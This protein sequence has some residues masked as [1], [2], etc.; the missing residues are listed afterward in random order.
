MPPTYPPACPG[1]GPAGSCRQLSTTQV[2][3]CRGR[4]DVQRAF[5]DHGVVV[6][7]TPV[8]TGVVHSSL[9]ATIT[10]EVT[11][12]GGVHEERAR[13]GRG[14]ARHRLHA[15]RNSVSL[16]I[17]VGAWWWLS[18]WFYFSLLLCCRFVF[19]CLGRSDR[20]TDLQ[21]YFFL[22][23]FVLFCLVV[24]GGEKSIIRYNS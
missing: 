15:H 8:H 13:E 3:T 1:G 23:Y 14:E 6:G 16:V 9:Y 20:C 17:V 2:L 11:R 4:A 5:H 21:T 18:S 19:V 24:V 10:A 7:V 12:V 22:Q